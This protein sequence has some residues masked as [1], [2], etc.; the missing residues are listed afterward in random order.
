MSNETVCDECDLPFN[1]EYPCAYYCES[2]ERAWHEKGKCPSSHKTEA[3]AM[4][5]KLHENP[6][7]HRL[8]SKNFGKVLVELMLATAEETLRL[9]A[10][11]RRP[12]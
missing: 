8:L 1:A 11:R 4:L 7:I 6:R 10:E 3:T 12:K 5:R 9:H 2:T